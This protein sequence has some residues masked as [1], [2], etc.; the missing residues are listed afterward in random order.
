MNKFNLNQNQFSDFINLSNKVFNPLKNF[1]NKDE[2]IK[3]LKISKYKKSYFPFPIFFGINKKKYE[4]Y[5]REKELIFFYQGQK[6]AKIK[7]LKF[8]SVDK[9]IFGRKIFGKNFHKHPYFQ[10]FKMEN[11]KFLNFKF[12][13][14]YIKKVNKNL[15]ISPKIFK[16]KRINKPIA[17]FH[18]RNVPH[19]CHKWIHEYLIKKYKSLLIQPLI[20]QYKKG[21][22]K[23]NVILSLNKEIINSYKNKK[24]I[25]VIP[26][27]SYPR[28]GG[29]REAALHA[30][31]RKNYGCTHFW[32]GRDHAGYK[33]FYKKFESQKFCKKNENNLGIK[34]IAKNEPYYCKNKKKVIDNCKCKKN[35]KVKISGSMIRK[36]I[37]KKSK[38]PKELMLESLSRKLTSKSLIS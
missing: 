24:N 31:V 26:F 34:I 20:G 30:L 17:S 19:N 3:I 38:I 25:F 23:D 37:L 6:I 36:L 4:L 5:K 12:E 35:C 1:V 2:F 21:E 27:F 7:N 11:H 15:F 18:T 8:Y 22:Y 33:N 32:V 16:K 29:P 28:Y 9:E 13:K 10:K 14:I